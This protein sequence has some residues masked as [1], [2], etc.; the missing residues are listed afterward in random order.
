MPIGLPR[1]AEPGGRTCE[2]LARAAMPG[3]GSC[4][5]NSPV[6]AA[7]DSADYHQASEVN[8]A[9]SSHRIKL[10]KQSFALFGKLRAVD[11]VADPATQDWFFEV[12]PELSF[13]RL[14]EEKRYDARLSSKATVMGARERLELLRE[15]GL[16]VE[17]LLPRRSQLR[18]TDIDIIDAAVAAW[19]ARR[20][21]LGVAH[22]L[23][24]S[25]ETDD[26]GLRMEMWA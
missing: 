26:R 10:S 18:A 7:L 22:R 23:P 6:R 11:G 19:T 1:A 3:R 13:T 24:E 25:P 8:A 15:A 12:H 14:V 4:V 17:P 16:D 20:K 9:S 5:F 21:A 2:R